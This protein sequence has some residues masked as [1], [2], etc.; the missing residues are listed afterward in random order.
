MP[1][2][3]R[4]RLSCTPVRRAML[5]IVSL[6]AWPGT[7][8][9]QP[10]IDPRWNAARPRPV[11]S[12]LESADEDGRWASGFHCA[13]TGS[14]VSPFTTYR[15]QLIVGGQLTWAGSSLQNS[16]AGWDGSSWHS[17]GTGVTGSVRALTVYN[18][19]LI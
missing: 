6:L 7:D 12:A 17:L 10:F 11:R 4:A 8:H 15:G 3:P 16:I 5:W 9:A 14:D 19:N 18:D 13:G 1:V 2:P